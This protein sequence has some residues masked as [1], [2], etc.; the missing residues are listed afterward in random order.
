MEKSK[1]GRVASNILFLGIL[2][3]VC[4]LPIAGYSY[5][6]FG[7]KLIIFL[8][9]SFASVILVFIPYTS[10]SLIALTMLRILLSVCIASLSC[11][12]LVMDMIRKE[13]RGKA[14]AI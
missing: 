13:S 7:R 3:G 4:I 12:P 11:H 10:P 8:A 14:S 2:A 9:V 6:M 1:Q 5:D